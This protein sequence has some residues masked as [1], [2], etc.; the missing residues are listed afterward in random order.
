LDCVTCLG[1]GFANCADGGFALL[2]Y[3]WSNSNSDE[4]EACSP[5]G[6]LGSI[7]HE[8]RYSVS[9]AEVSGTAPGWCFPCFAA[10]AN[11]IRIRRIVAMVMQES[12]TL[13][14]GKLI[15]RK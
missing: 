8:N 12:A 4:E 1:N 11:H 3:D 9:T 7:V 14:T 10:S 15:D 6:N 13:N 2:D 5:S